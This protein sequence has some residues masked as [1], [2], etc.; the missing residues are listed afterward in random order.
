MYAVDVLKSVNAY[1]GTIDGDKKLRC[2]D[3]GIKASV[4]SERGKSTAYFGPGC[5]VKDLIYYI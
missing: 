3:M 4:I 5:D 1:L 2:D